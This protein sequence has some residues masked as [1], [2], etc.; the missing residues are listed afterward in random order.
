[1]NRD[2][3][4]TFEEFE[5]ES[6]AFYLHFV[7][8]VGKSTFGDL[9]RSKTHYI[10]CVM[11]QPEFAKLSAELLGRNDRLSPEYLQK[12][13]SAY[14]FMYPYAETNHELFE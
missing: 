13:Y 9:Y 5:E 11:A 10:W 12:L 3:L 8:P 6:R 7:G 2:K 1:M 4:L 14:L